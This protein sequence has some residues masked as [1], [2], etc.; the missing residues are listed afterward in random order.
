MKKKGF[1]MII[2]HDIPENSTIILR[3]TT[4]FGNYPLHRHNNYEIEYVREGSGTVIING[5][6]YEFSVGTLWFSSM[7]DFHEFHSTG[8][9]ALSSIS[10]RADWI[11]PELLNHLSKGT[12]IQNYSAEIINRF[13]N[14]YQSHAFGNALY[15]KHLLG[16]ILIDLARVIEK[17][18]TEKIYTGLSQ[19][20]SIALQYIQNHFTEDIKLS[21]ISRI[22]GLAP[23]YFSSCF[24]REFGT[25]FQSYLVDI[26]LQAAKKLLSSTKTSVIDICYLCGFSN[27][28]NFN[29]AFKNKHN[30]TPLQYRKLKTFDSL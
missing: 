24:H 5:F 7:T 14:E 18:N 13:S 8:K 20:V 16:C 9:I 25:T 22:V 2:K 29:R 21:D 19:P 23:T 27:Y 17:E 10:F 28:A 1:E 3:T 12:I 6:P 30:I 26:R 11:E 4:I 15:I